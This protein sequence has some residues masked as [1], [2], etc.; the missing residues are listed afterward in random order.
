MKGIGKLSKKKSTPERRDQILSLP[1][2]LKTIYL[3]GK[4]F[5][6]HMKMCPPPMECEDL[7]P[8]GKKIREKKQSYKIRD[9]YQMKKSD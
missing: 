4:E 6:V 7:F 9:N 1:T 2:E 5:T 8:E 3:N